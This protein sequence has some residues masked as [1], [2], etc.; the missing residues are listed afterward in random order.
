MAEQ[1][2]GSSNEPQ[3]IAELVGTV[4]GERYQLDRVLGAG[5]MGA[6]FEGKD[7]RLGRGVAIKVMQPG[8]ARD[9]EYT[10]RFLREAQT[11]SKIRH[12]NVVVILDYGKADGGLVYSVMEF[13]VGQDLEELL[14]GQPEQR[15]PW[16]Q[17]C[18]LL[19]QIA[20]GLKAAHGQGVIHRDIKP[21]NCFLTM[22]DDEPVVK[23]VDFGIAKLDDAAQTQQ[24]T[25]TGNVLGTPS[26]TAPEMVLSNGPVSPRSDVYSLGVVAYRMLTGRLPFTGKTAFE[27]MHHACIHPVPGMREQGVELPAGVEALVIAMLAKKP[28]ERPADMGEV[29]QRLQAL[30][31]EAGGVQAVVEAAGSSSLRIEVGG[32]GAS[33]A[34]GEVVRTEVFDSGKREP[35]GSPVAAV[36]VERT[37]V[38]DSGVSGRAGVPERVVDAGSLVPG[39]GEATVRMEDAAASERPRRMAAGWLVA[40]GVFVVALGGLAWS[41]MV[42]EGVLEGAAPEGGGSA[43]A[44]VEPV[45]AGGGTAEQRPEPREAVTKPPVAA[46][47]ESKRVAVVEG[48]EPAVEPVVKVEDVPVAEPAVVEEPKAVAKPEKP[49]PPVGPPSDAELKKKLARKIKAKCATEMGGQSVTVSFFVTPSGGVDSLTATPK[50]AAGECAKQQLAG[51]RFRT[52]SGGETAIK[53]VVD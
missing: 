1:Q 47:E 39:R 5:G 17:A 29:R 48:D 52:R 4:L 37:A 38:F 43:V 32:A 8:Y 50:N 51:A 14:R 2:Q 49:K 15:M 26:Y 22:E 23:V 35:S 6:V 31:R 27:V 40:G 21:A 25:G 13:L 44:V 7:L 12:R 9:A 3:A 24:L 34:A 16:V 30:A 45:R 36:Q 20:S 10:K 19:V 46:D 11:A 53:I 28:E 18:G 33:G 42:G 41:T